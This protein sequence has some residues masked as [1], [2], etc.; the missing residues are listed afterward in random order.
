M[1]SITEIFG[2]NLS[3]LMKENGYSQVDVA[4]YLGV[5][6]TAVRAWVKCVSLPRAKEI[7]KLCDLF[8]VTYNDFVTP[9]THESL[10]YGMLTSQIITAAEEL[11][12]EGKV[13]VLGYI[14]D[15]KA[16]FPRE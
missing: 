3:L 4:A 11:N 13:R 7:D 1:A 6:P 9:Q 8:N 14:N 5:S 16:R 12:D 10:T 2:N 15:I